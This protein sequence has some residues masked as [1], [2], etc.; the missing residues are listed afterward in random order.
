M[1][2]LLIVL[3]IGVF[4]YSCKS[5]DNTPEEENLVFGIEGTHQVSTVSQSG[6]QYSTAYYP[7]DISTM[8][9]KT[10]VIFFI[11]G[12]SADTPATQYDSLLRFIAS[13]GYT[14]IYQLQGAVTT[15]NFAINGFDSFLNSDD[16]IIKNTIK[17]RLDMTKLGVLG[18]SA[19]GGETLTVLKYFTDL[20]YGSNGKLVMMYDPWYAFDMN[21]ADFQQLPSDTNVILEQFGEGGNNDAN[22][23]DARIPLTIY[24]LL[25]SIP[26]DHKDYY[27]Y[28]QQNADHHYL[29]GNGP[30]T[31]MQ[32]ILK[33]LDALMYYTF[34]DNQSEQARVVAL[35]NGNDDPYNNGN[36]IQV[37]L[38]TYPYP[39]DGAN[40]LIDYCAIVP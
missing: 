8:E 28:D 23:T 29:Y 35:E 2:K 38:P 1:N 40:T 25:T 6:N 33:P 14:V 34:E 21:V 30:Y 22:G 15:S 27:V 13:H 19:G 16:D 5:D 12:W 17:P 36:G 4:F 32:G 37:V 26:N 24:S 11:S 18:H 7:S 20:G 3:V 10:P 39:C 9:N 31:D